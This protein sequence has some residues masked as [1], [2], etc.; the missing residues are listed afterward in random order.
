MP[1]PDPSLDASQPRAEQ[2]FDALRLN[3][4]SDGLFAIVLTLLVLD[5][6]LPEN[7][8]AAASARELL[9]LLVPA[10]S[11]YL[12]TFVIAG[13]Y[14]ILHIRVIESL[15]VVTRQLLWINLMLLLSVGLL[16]FSSG[17]LTGDNNLG[18]P[19]YS[20]N[21]I[22]IGVTQAALWGYAAAAGLLKEEQQEPRHIRTVLWR[23]LITPLVFAFVFVLL[24]IVPSVAQFLPF[25][26]IPANMLIREPRQPRARLFRPGWAAFWRWVSFAPIIA[27]VVVLVWL[28]T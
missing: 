18:Y 7:V 12:I 21:M 11:G 16:P 15:R 24:P 9:D 19:F 6:R 26:I 17:A 1:T 2:T 8:S 5:I 22:L 25:A 23:T 10:L 4:L 20:V 13:V 28:Y 3:A 14:W 27:F